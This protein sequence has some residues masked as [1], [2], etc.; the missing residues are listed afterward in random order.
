MDC[1][2]ILVEVPEMSAFLFQAVTAL[3][4]SVIKSAHWDWKS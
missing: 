1:P 3:K 4:A 2:V